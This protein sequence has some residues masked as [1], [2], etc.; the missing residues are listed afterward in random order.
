MTA[1]TP[2]VS[3]ILRT[4]NRPDYLEQALEGLAG[5]TLHDFEALVINDGGED[6]ADLLATF[7]GRVEVRYF[8]HQPGRGRCAAANRGL[9]EARGLFIAYLDDDDL[10]HPDHLETLVQAL[11]SGPADVAYA[12]AYEVIQTPA[13]DGSGY[14]DVSRE[15]KLDH[16]FSRVRFFLHS[17]IHLVTLMHRASCIQR[18][19]RFD[20]SLD[21]LE[22]LDLYFRLS[23]QYDF[24]HVPR[25]TAEYRIRDDATNAVTALTLEFQETRRRIYLKYNHLILPELIKYTEHKDGI[26][27][28]LMERVDDLERRLGELEGR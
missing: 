17:Y 22:D 19:G 14:V 27:T 2:K 10:Y 13:P 20:E 18:V 7:E 23:Q 8:H 6:V 25:I 26:V 9:A 28:R 15:V 5:Q 4:R 16:D 21:V 1:A 3:V 12:N 11:E 24:V